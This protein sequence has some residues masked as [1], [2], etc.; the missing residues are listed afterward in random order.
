MA[1]YPVG[2]KYMASF[3]A[4][5]TRKRSNHETL[6]LAEQWMEAKEVEREA[7]AV[8]LMPPAPV[9]TVWTLQ[10]AFDYTLKHHWTAG[11]G[12]ENAI[13]NSGYALEFFGPNT[14]IDKIVSTSVISYMEWLIEFR[15]NSHSTLNKKLSALRVILTCALDIGGISTLPRL[16][17]YK[18]NKKI[19]HW[20]SNA[21]ERMML[22]IATDFGYTDLHDFIVFGFDLGMRR[23]ELLNLKMVDYHQGSLLIHA[24]KSKSGKARA[25]PTTDRVKAILAARPDG[26]HKVFANLNEFTHRTQWEQL[27]EAMDRVDDPF[28]ITHSMR[29]T[30]AT[31]LVSAGAKMKAVQAWLGHE[32]M[33]STMVYS[34]L[35][36]GQLE[37]ALVSLEQRDKA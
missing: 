19:P 29:H 14:L 27:R 11:G 28:F 22:K 4:G 18:E 30:C 34:H 9:S 24:D 26:Q 25:V 35:E 31:R 20:F 16:K 23:M 1:I 6:E 2:N 5:K 8:L 13:R 7:A 37:Q 3:G 17:R 21:D 12:V 10:R 32:A 15:N 36:P 33:A